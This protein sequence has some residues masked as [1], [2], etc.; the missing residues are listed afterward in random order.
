MP[1]LLEDQDGMNV[2]SSVSFD[3]FE[4]SMVPGGIPRRV[5]GVSR[6]G[7][8]RFMTL[9]GGK[10][11]IQNRSRSAPEESVPPVLEPIGP[12]LADRHGGGPGGYQ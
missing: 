11:G 7:F 12:T 4:S 9:P 3:Q 10:E 2:S 5:R 6:R 1:F 8:A